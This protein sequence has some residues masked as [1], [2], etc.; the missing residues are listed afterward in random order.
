[1]SKIQIETLTPV[2]I[3]SGVSFEQNRDYLFFDAERSIGVVQPDRVLQ[4]ISGGETAQLNDISK[5]VT[6]IDNRESI[7]P[8]LL[9]RKPDLKAADISRRVLKVRG[10]APVTDKPMREQI[11][12]GNEQPYIP[13]SSL[14]GSIRTA[15]LD[16]LI[17][18]DEG[19][20]VKNARNLK[21]F[22]GK[23][24][25]NQLMEHYFGKDPNHDV[26][27]LIQVGDAYFDQTECL[28]TTVINGKQDGSWTTKPAINQ[29][30]EVIPKGA[31]TTAKL[32][33]NA[34]MLKATL[35]NSVKPKGKDREKPPYKIF[36]DKKTLL[37][38][39]PL[40]TL[41]KNINDHTAALIEA[42]IDFWLNEQSNPEP[43]G[44]YVEILQ[45]ILEKIDQAKPNECILRLGWGTG[46]LNMTGDW[47]YWYMDRQDY[48]D[49][50]DF[51][52]DGKYGGMV[53]PKTR[54][55]IEGGMPLGFLKLTL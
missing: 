25:A 42:E 8:F 39:L 17:K 52:R 19:A 4:V 41:F 36:D 46:Y 43:L 21:N 37:D 30:I 50:V 15:F 9:Q 7:L 26:L 49:M 6:S 44:D 22:K 34:D 28:Y 31:T 14:K 33:L 35:K 12:S 3:G 45:S 29:Y 38:L 13:G 53:Y 47:Q 2:H 51:I 55:L 10:T 24:D 32:S 20:Y 27:R 11:H 18:A 48:D 1:M 16:R 54:R 5:W 23:Y 40:Q